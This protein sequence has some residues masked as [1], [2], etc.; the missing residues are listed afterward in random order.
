[1]ANRANHYEAAFEAYIRALRLPCVA[2]DEAKRAF[3][4]KWE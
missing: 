2:V 4:V 1:M 3:P